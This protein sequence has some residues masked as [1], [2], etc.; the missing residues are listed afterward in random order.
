M[1]SF[2]KYHTSFLLVRAVWNIYFQ[3]RETLELYD[4][5]ALQR[6]IHDVF[7]Y[8]VNH[9]LSTDHLLHVPNA[10]PPLPSDWQVHST[11]PIRN[12]PYFL[13]PLWDAGVRSRSEEIASAKKLATAQ[14]AG[15]SPIDT[16]GR[17]PA[18]LRQKLKKSKGAKTL[19]QDLEEEIRKFVRDYERKERN[20][21]NKGQD[22]A[23]EEKEMDSE[24]EEIVFVGRDGTMSDEQRKKIEVE[25]EREKMVFDGLVGDQGAGFAR[26]LVHSI[27]SYY[28][29]TSRSVTVGDPEMKREIWVGI[30]DMK[31]GR[32]KSTM[33]ESELPRPLWGMI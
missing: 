6:T 4:R 8:S 1:V 19:L 30:R 15:L 7:E 32:G 12:V 24:D 5:I 10:Q 2:E 18:E 29:L 33:R 21:L 17:V 28:G 11:S 3:W 22:E 14:R 27:A 16:K 26:W 20:R 31:S 9:S 13:A 25:L 23:E